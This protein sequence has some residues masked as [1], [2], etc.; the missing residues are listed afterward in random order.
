MDMV[1]HEQDGFPLSHVCTHQIQVVKRR[2]QVE[3]AGRLIKDQHRWPVDQSSCEQ[4]TSL[5]TCRHGGIPSVGQLAD[6]QILHD[7]MG[8]ND[9]RIGKLLMPVCSDTRVVPG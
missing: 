7:G 1:G 3:P 8:P 5:L 2:G 4:T 9:L 6:S